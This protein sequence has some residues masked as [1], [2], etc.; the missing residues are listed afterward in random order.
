MQ[1]SRNK[2]AATAIAIFL[3]LTIAA[4]LVALPT[5]NAHYPAWT[6]KVWCYATVTNSIIGVNQQEVIVFW[7]NALPPT[8]Q[9]AYGD[10]W[11]FTIDITKPDGTKETLPPLT[12]DPVGG[13]WVA[14][15]PTQ[16]GNY[17]VVA[18]MLAH[19]VTGLPAPPGG[20]FSG[21]ATIN[22]TYGP[23]T[24]D[25]VT[26][27]VQQEPIQPW[28]EAPLPTGYWTRPINTA[29][30]NWYALAGNWLAGAAQNVNATTSFGYGT[31][32]ESAHILWATPMMYG[33]VMDARFGDIGYVTSHYEGLS[34]SPPIILNG[35]IYYNAPNAE[36]RVGYYCLDLYTG[37]LLSFVN[38]T[39]PVTGKGGGF[40]AHGGITGDSL[41]V[42]QIYNYESPNQ[43]GGYAYLWS[44]S[45][46]QGSGTWDMFDA[47]TNYYIC[48]IANVTQ[49]EVRGTS[50]TTTG[51]T[52]T[53]VY[54]KDGSIL[55]YNLANLG[56]AT[57]PK[58]YLQVWNTS[59]AI[60]FKPQGWGTSNSYWMWRPYLNT[61]F[62]GRNGFSL[63]VSVPL[64]SGTT[65][66]A[67]REDQYIF[68]GTAGSNNEQGITQGFMWCLNLKPDS[69][70]IITPALIWNKTFTPPSSAGNITVSIGAVDPED[71]VFTFSCTQLR[72]RWGFS[73][74][75]MAQLW[76]VHPKKK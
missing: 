19:V 70:G 2:T 65:I 63:N 27:T 39:G 44:T 54:G 75:T 21:A 10:R 64:T 56:N 16:I 37:K 30:R 25:P 33:G 73:L 46:Y 53:N 72:K 22:D 13:A 76:R 15:V 60:W 23:A 59:Q 68:G 38:T 17:T 40:D 18:H 6:V 45:G 35:R 29:N 57:V 31:G 43:H 61:T 3:V 32:P 8:A 66:R 47:Y 28:P 55:Y 74:D 41:A 20:L 14:Y 42:G 71:G 12:S 51:A 24:S 26:F 11:T 50:T 52:G 1:I 9:G 34:F 49:T 69:N 48:S 7:I 4:T 58:Y 62:D 5:V 67:V 36:M